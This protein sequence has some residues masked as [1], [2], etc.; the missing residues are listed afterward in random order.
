MPLRTLQYLDVSQ[1]SPRV[2]SVLIGAEGL[3]EAR[4]A[5]G[6]K[7]VTTE[8]LLTAL[9][10]EQDGPAA[11]LFESWGGRW[12]EQ[13]KAWRMPS[14][15]KLMDNPDRR[16]AEQ[17]DAMRARWANIPGPRR[18]VDLLSR[19]FDLLLTAAEALCEERVRLRALHADGEGLLLIRDWAGEPDRPNHDDEADVG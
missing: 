6:A 10:G 11:V 2:I 17:L 18:N 1:L 3:L 15:G 13:R 9:L 4:A 14:P 16:T 19:D 8:D 12:D 7:Y 5:H